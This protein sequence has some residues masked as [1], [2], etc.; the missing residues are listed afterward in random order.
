MTEDKQVHREASFLK[1]GKPGLEY[2]YPVTLCA[3]NKQNDSRAAPAF[4][5][6]RMGLVIKNALSDPPP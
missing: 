6:R 1:T 2:M 5:L 3:I 4:I